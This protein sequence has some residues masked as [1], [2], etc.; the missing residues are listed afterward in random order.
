ML[1]TVAKLKIILLPHIYHESEVAFGQAMGP[2]NVVKSVPNRL[3]AIET[4]VQSIK[5]ISKVLALISSAL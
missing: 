3:V 1:S 4:R 5:S 2:T